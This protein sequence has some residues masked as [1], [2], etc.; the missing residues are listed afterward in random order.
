MDSLAFLLQI[1]E[2]S[3]R[4]ASS[5]PAMQMLGREVALMTKQLES[6]LQR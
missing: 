5:A 4:F 2:I 3:T 6:L 1:E